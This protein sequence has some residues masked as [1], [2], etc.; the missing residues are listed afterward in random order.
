MIKQLGG[1]TGAVIA[2]ACCLG[3]AP[4]LAALTAVGAGF[5]IRD[6]ILVPLFVLFLAFTLWSLW[7]SRAKHRQTG[8]FYLGL[9]SAVIAFAALWFSPPLA[10]AGLV[11]FIAA[12]VWD[13]V[14]L[15]QARGI[16]ETA[17][18]G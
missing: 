5:L 6:A 4:L 15:R 18:G 3:F 16:A 2:G 17:G 1:T 9:G 11:G 12:S 13:I 10:Y 7:G 14:A 8:P